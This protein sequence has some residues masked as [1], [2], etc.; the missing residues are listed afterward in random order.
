M[1]YPRKLWIEIGEKD[2]LFDCKYG[3]DSFEKLKEMCGNVGCEWVEFIVFDGVHEF[4]MSDE[5]IES[6]VS[7]LKT[8]GCED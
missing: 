8:G 5:P 7:E 6:F 4:C 3:K 1:I 2:D